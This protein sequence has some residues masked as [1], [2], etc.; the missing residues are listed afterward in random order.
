MKIY[1]Y[2]R[3][4]GIVVTAFGIWVL[5]LILFLLVGGCATPTPV[6]YI[7]SQDEYGFTITHPPGSPMA[8]WWDLMYS[9]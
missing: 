4:E 7:S 5:F 8:I 1:P 2:G 9:D 3:D 6:S